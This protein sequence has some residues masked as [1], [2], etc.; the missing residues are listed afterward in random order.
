M[1]ARLRF[2]WVVLTCGG[3]L[4]AL[5]ILA[6][7]LLAPHFGNSVYIWGSIISVFLAALSVGYLWGGRMADRNPTLPSLARLIALAATCQAILLL[8]GHR[9]VAVFADLTGGRPSGTL[10]TTAV[11]FGPVSVLLATVSPYAVR[12]AARD[13]AHLGNTAGRLYALSNTG[14]LA[15]T[16]GCTFLL[17]PFLDLR[18]SMA[19]LLS[20]TAFTAGVAILGE[21]RQQKGTA[22]L[23]LALLAM[24]FPASTLKTRAGSDIIYER[25][26]PYQTLQVRDFGGVRYLESDGVRQGG[27]FTR[28]GSTALPYVTF[29]PA[30]LLLNPDIRSGLGVGLGTGS[31]GPFLKQRIP[32]LS[33]DYVEIDPAVAD[34]ARSYFGFAEG[35]DMTVAIADGRTFLERSEKKWDLIYSDAYI[36]LSVPFHLTTV[37]FL[38]VAKRHLNPGGIFAVNLAQG[39]V[40]PFS[41]SMYWTIRQKFSAVYLFAVSGANNVLVVATDGSPRSREDLLARARELAPRFRFDPTLETIAGRWT[42]VSLKT[43]EVTILSDQFAPTDRLIRLGRSERQER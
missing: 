10:L 17:I 33:F 20:L 22:A 18:Q 2:Y 37:E 23:C 36:G 39:L 3:V 38:D 29:A 8:V 42:E 9:L 5:E 6:S 41:R 40:D 14:S 13:L 32:D 35:E 28:D 25:L 11:L 7:R 31:L 30:V 26:S 12:L 1:L 43:D 27:I 19:L 21:L 15:G 16:L 4:M 34:V 24:A